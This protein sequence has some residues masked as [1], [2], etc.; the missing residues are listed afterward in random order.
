VRERRLALALLGAAFGLI[1]AVAPASTSTSSAAT[2]PHAT[3]AAGHLAEGLLVAE[4]PRILGHVPLAVATS[5]TTLPSAPARSASDRSDGRPGPAVL[6]PP[7]A[8]R[9]PPA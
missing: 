8:I 3:L 6:S 7:A 1:V 9:G 4:H 2:A 5:A